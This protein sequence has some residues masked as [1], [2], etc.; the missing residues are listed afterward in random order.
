VSAAE[1]KPIESISSFIGGGAPRFWYSRVSREIASARIDVRQLESGDS[2]GLPVAIRISGEDIGTLRATAERV[3]RILGNIPL[4]SRVRDNWGEDRFN[5]EL[6]VD[7]DRANLAG[8]TNLDVAGS[9]S[10]AISGTSLTALREGDKQI[11]VVARLRSD[12]IAGLND[13]SNLYVY[14]SSGK[15]KVP[16]RQVAHLDYSFRSEV[17]RRL[18]QFRTITVSAAPQP[19]VLAS[20]VMTLANPELKSLSRSLA[21]TEIANTTLRSSNPSI[22]FSS[23]P[24][25]SS[26]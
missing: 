11:P 13:V 3:K 15:Q 24:P 14:S 12:E 5:V 7:S 10:T 20:E 6:K 26:L 23:S 9:S 18:N 17:I 19:G 16:V 25:T 22:C 4:A 1:K 2:V 8:L 21:A